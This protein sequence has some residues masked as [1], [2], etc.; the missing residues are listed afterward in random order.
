LW[1]GVKFVCS[2][3][4]FFGLPGFFFATICSNFTSYFGYISCSY[5]LSFLNLFKFCS[6]ISFILAFL[7]PLPFLIAI[8]GNP[9]IWF[10]PELFYALICCIIAL[11]LPLPLPIGLSVL[12][13]LPNFLYLS[14]FIFFVRGNG[15]ISNL[16]F[17]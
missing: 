2:I 5:F 4:I 10:C 13:I 7:F 14:F 1:T 6:L 3:L 12:I 8:T 17:L 16:L 15:R 9:F 11:L